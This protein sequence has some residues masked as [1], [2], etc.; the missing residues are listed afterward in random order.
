MNDNLKNISVDN[1]H[2][3]F[4]IISNDINFT[5]L[6]ANEKFYDFINRSQDEVHNIFLSKFTSIISP[7]DIENIKHSIISNENKCIIN[8]RKKD[9]SLILSEINICIKEDNTY[10][11]TLC[12]NTDSFN[13]EVSYKILQDKFSFIALKTRSI[14]FEYF[15]NKKYAIYYLPDGKEKFEL[16]NFPQSI[17]ESQ[18]VH[19]ESAEVFLSMINDID[20]GK[21]YSSCEARLKDIK[22]NRY[23]WFMMAV[24]KKVYNGEIVVSGIGENISWKKESTMA[25]LRKTRSYQAFI[26]DTDASAQIDVTTNRI[27]KLE[28]LWSKYSE[29]AQ[30]LSFT[31]IALKYIE[32][33]VHPLDKDKYI[34]TL[35]VNNLTI[36][37][38]SGLSK[39]LYEYRRI[40][41]DDKIVW[42]RL[43]IHLFPD[44][45]NNNLM[46]LLYLNN[47]DIEKKNALMLQRESRRDHLTNCY[48]R[49][50][51]ET[52]IIDY[53]TNN[54]TPIV[55]AIFDIDNF[56]M[57][58][59]TYGHL[60]GDKILIKFVTILKDNLNK[61]DIIGRFGGDEFIVL[62][63]DFKSKEYIENIFKKIITSFSENC[64]YSVTCSVGAVISEEKHRYERLFKCADIALYTA[65]GK[66]KNTYAF[67]DEV[68]ENKTFD[69][70]EVYI[71]HRQ[72]NLPQPTINKKN[73][74]NI[75]NN[76]FYDIINE[77]SD[78]YYLVDTETY[79]LIEANQALFNR[80]GLSSNECLG[81]KC[82]EILYGRQTPCSFCSKLN[83]TEDKFYIWKNYNNHLEQEFIIKN[84]LVKYK[85]N[86]YMFAVAVDISSNKNIADFADYSANT[87]RILL[88]C[89]YKIT[90][91]TSLDDSIDTILNSI[92]QFYNA[93]SIEF[94]EKTMPEG[95]YLLTAKYDISEKEENYT[96]YEQIMSYFLEEGN[97]KNIFIESLEE[98]LQ[99]SYDI[100][101]YMSATS[102]KNLRIVELAEKDNVFGSIIIKNTKSYGKYTSFLVSI[103]FFIIKEIK[104]YRREGTIEYMRYHDVM[105]NLLNRI[106]Y[107]KY[108]S[109]YNPKIINSIGIASININ[110]LRKINSSLGNDAG[111]N[112]LKETAN[113][114]HKYFTSSQIYRISGDEFLVISENINREV[115]EENCLNYKN[116]IDKINEYS[117]SIGYIWDNK[118]KNLKS[119]IRHSNELMKINKQVYHHK[120]N[121]D[122]S[123]PQYSILNELLTYIDKGNF[124]VYYQPKKDIISNK[125][126]GAEALIRFNDNGKILPP[127]DF[128]KRYEVNGMA[129]Y[130]DFFVFEEVCKL[131]K[132]I[133]DNNY[134]KLKISVNFSKLT[135]FESN[136]ITNIENIA[137][138][139]NINRKSLEIEITES[140]SD[141]GSDILSR[142][143]QEIKNSGFSVSLDDF[144]MM[145]SNLSTLVNITFD[146]IKLDKSLVDSI[147]DNKSN[148]IILKN[149]INMCTEL[150]SETIAEGIETKEQE[151]ELS[152]LGCRYFQGYLYDK[153]ISLKD[154]KEKYL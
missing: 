56:K 1:I 48:N 133:N 77:K 110:D 5:I 34:S 126:N 139:Y 50:M 118:D 120:D 74:E 65:K 127:A 40:L 82:Y 23:M 11:C 146:V 52:S 96:N 121:L 90:E 73:N 88:D 15:P 22:T 119:L 154:F 32:K 137:N 109:Q 35:D 37:Y 10:Y 24:V 17:I 115:F 47:I 94:W 16:S 86:L 116:K 31:D 113:L 69:N 131:L 104:K 87:E 111:N 114:L 41:E 80:V 49:R 128:L 101:Q 51:L 147:S 3:P 18:I 71:P 60:V 27:I 95:K 81:Q 61:S 67:Y 92:S 44:P 91:T 136:F 33:V 43:T 4:F 55:Y 46:A 97:H 58:N 129:R 12:D 28:G 98:T 2:I 122:N 148:K 7:K 151:I 140:I 29:D 79:E 64:P 30:H 153:P 63:K 117:V 8:I 108:E 26:S 100:H 144:G 99:Y 89:I 36:N 106:S 123:N 13:K 112:I 83:W 152:K 14:T 93:D 38:N 62:F 25:Y 9:G 72:E 135:L 143:T 53:I 39:I 125:I 59:D 134:N 130:I 70:G 149:I 57:I 75:I 42:M 145:H 103:T 66:G 85:N 124:I 76:Q 107:D 138:K 105:T 141:M 142:I 6:Y 45:V 21:L 78:M 54:N 84:K 102:V 150:G 20:T 68:E 132:E 19:P